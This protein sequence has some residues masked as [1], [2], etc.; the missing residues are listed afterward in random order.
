[1]ANWFLYGFSGWFY[2]KLYFYSSVSNYYMGF[3]IE[4]DFTLWTSSAD[5]TGTAGYVKVHQPI[6]PSNLS[7]LENSI[8]PEQI[9]L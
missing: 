6:Y 9:D 1:M 3:A 5:K 4:D 2:E 8:S 7:L